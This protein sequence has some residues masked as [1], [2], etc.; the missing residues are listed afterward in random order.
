MSADGRQRVLFIVIAVL[1]V[2]LTSPSLRSGLVA[3]DLLHQNHIQQVLKDESGA[4]WWDLFLFVQDNPALVE[5]R[6]LRGGVP[7]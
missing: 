7:W 2:T 1:G 5:A 6:R 3:D 4:R